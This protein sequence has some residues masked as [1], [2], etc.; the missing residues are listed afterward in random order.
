V[1]KVTY[2][3]IRRAAAVDVLAQKRARL[4]DVVWPEW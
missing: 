2:E 3:E 4:V 1:L